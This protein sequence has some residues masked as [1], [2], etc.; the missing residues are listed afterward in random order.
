MPCDQEHTHMGTLDM[1]NQ[2]TKSE[3]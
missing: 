3:D 2:C 1:A